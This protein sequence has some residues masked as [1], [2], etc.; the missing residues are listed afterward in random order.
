LDSVGLVSDVPSVAFA[1]RELSTLCSKFD[2]M[3][4]LHLDVAV[5]FVWWLM[6]CLK[7]R[8]LDRVGGVIDSPLKVDRKFVVDVGRGER[9]S[10]SDGGGAK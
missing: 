10:E 9:A 5:V 6:V 2:I 8:G 4:W 7:P 1:R 3:E